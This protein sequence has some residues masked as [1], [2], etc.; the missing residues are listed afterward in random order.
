MF[1]S[2]KREDRRRI[3]PLARALEE[4]GYTVWWDLEIVAGDKWKRRIKQELDAAR[5]VIVAWS[6]NSV[7]TDGLYVSEWI[8]REAEDGHARGVLVPALFDAGR[9]AWEHRQVQCADLVGWSGDTAHA[10]FAA[11]IEGVERRVGSKQRPEAREIAAWKATEAA[12]NADAFAA[13]AR[14]F[15][16]SRFASVAKGRA[17]EFAQAE[18]ETG[19]AGG[20]RDGGRDAPSWFQSSRGRRGVFTRDRRCVDDRRW[21]AQPGRWPAQCHGRDWARGTT[22]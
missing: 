3:Q 16:Q 1:I 19:G 21:A 15:P 6:A 9:I 18:K 13:F 4:R 7:G 12:G 2:Y 10:G 11:V 14:D 5:C 17:A 20:A 22:G 8:E